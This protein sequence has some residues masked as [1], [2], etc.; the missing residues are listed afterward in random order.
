MIMN[1]VVIAFVLG[2]A[3]FWLTKGAFSSL[4]HLCCTIAAGAIAFAVWEPL[5]YTLVGVMPST[6]FFGFLQGI[7]WT[8]A[9]VVPFVIALI[10]L[11]AIVDSVVRANLTLAGP[12][13]MGLAGAC[14]LGSAVLTAGVVVIGLSYARLSTGFAGYQPLWYTEEKAEGA[15]SLVLDDALWLPADKLTAGLYGHVSR[16]AFATSEP[17]AKW[18]P[19]LHATGFANRMGPDDGAS[20]NAVGRDAFSLVRRYTV[21]DGTEAERLL[22]DQFGETAQKYMDVRGE[23]VASGRLEGFVLKFGAGSKDKG[24]SG[25]GPVILSN[26][27]TRVIAEN[28]DGKT[29]DIFPVAVV[30]QASS[31]ERVYGRWRFDADEVFIASVGAGDPLMAVEF[32]VPEG[33]EAIGL[34]HRGIRVE[35]GE[36]AE[37]RSFRSAAERDAVTLDGGLLEGGAD[38]EPSFVLDRSKAESLTVD[39]DDRRDPSGVA[40]TDDLGWT[41]NVQTIR[42]G[43][44]SISEDGNNYVLEGQSKFFPEQFSKRPSEKTLRCDSFGTARD[45]VMIQIDVSVG[46]PGTLTGPVPAE[47]SGSLPLQLVSTDG[48]TFRA[49]GYV[50]EDNDEIEIR[51]TPSSPLEGMTE[52]PSLSRSAPERQLRLLFVVSRGVD[53]EA[54]AIGETAVLVF[55]PAVESDS[56]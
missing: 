26:G 43:G 1:L 10:A 23:R 51:Y 13:D 45:Q 39:A 47:L 52:L 38:G 6:G 2:V 31:G 40:L 32:L 36:G 56:D 55:D 7:S 8:L 25:P 28:A 21:G 15:G 54:F 48:Q 30:S 14:G 44:F 53:I 34:V 50:Y 29:I 16:H 17:L 33:Y 46:M 27:N 35:L 4:L 37:P 41:V 19:N 24:K 18:Y 11:R 49:L 42:G 9:L 5:A 3:W 22:S 12:V 20:R